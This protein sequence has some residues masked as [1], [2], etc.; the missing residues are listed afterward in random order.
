MPSTANRTVV[1]TG[2]AWQP[3]VSPAR[4]KCERSTGWREQTEV[5]THVHAHTHTHAHAHGYVLHI[6]YRLLYT[7]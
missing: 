3:P 5:N 6:A 1:G 2:T 4:V 7:V